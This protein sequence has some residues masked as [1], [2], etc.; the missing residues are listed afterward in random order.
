[1]IYVRFGR[2]NLERAGKKEREEAC[3]GRLVPSY[4]ARCSF[5]TNKKERRKR[6]RPGSRIKYRRLG[7]IEMPERGEREKEKGKTKLRQKR[8]AVIIEKGWKKDDKPA[9]PAF[10]IRIPSSGV[11]QEI[12]EGCSPACL[13]HLLYL[14]TAASP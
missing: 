8:Q 3:T 13:N 4:I 9:A 6:T 10:P 2:R 11:K 5:F 7:E 12:K 1:L 14:T